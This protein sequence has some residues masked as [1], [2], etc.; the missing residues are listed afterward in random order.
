MVVAV[1][2]MRVVE[3]TVDN[4]VYVVPMRNR[5]VSAAGTMNM[6]SFVSLTGVLRCTVRWILGTDLKGMLIHMV[7]VGMVEVTI[8]EIVGVAVVLNGCMSAVWSVN[9]TVILMSLAFACHLL[10]LQSL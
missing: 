8:V 3:M 9:M 6:I 7:S 2:S 4:V 5:F 1:L 10:S